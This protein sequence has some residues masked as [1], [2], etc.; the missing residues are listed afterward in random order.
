ME[1]DVPRLRRDALERISCYTLRERTMIALINEFTDIPD[2][3]N[4]IYDAA[5]LETWKYTKLHDGRDITQNMIN[6]VRQ[7]T[8]FAETPS[9]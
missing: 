9:N 4:L 7:E 5:K 6:Y 3:N 2:W 8:S 1:N